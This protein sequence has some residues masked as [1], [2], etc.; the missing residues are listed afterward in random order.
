MGR[1]LLLHRRHSH[2]ALCAWHSTTPCAPTRGPRCSAGCAYRPGALDSTHAPA[3]HKPVEV[4]ADSAYSCRE[5][6]RHLP[7]GVVFV[8]ALRADSTLHRPRSRSCRS[9]VTGRLLTKDILLPKPEKIARD[10]NHP[11]LTMTLTL[12]GA[13]TQV[14]YKESVIEAY[15][16]RWGIEVL[17]RDLKQQLGFASS[18]ARSPGGAT[19]GSLGGVGG[20]APSSRPVAPAHF[21]AS[22]ES[23]MSYGS[24]LVKNGESRF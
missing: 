23:R 9:P 12:Y 8:G 24:R 3:H 17:F 20:P 4:V 13:P 21:S 6:L 10:D 14:Q 19:D 7:P 2:P 15:G 5:V 18:R 22:A 1:L 16:N 11:W